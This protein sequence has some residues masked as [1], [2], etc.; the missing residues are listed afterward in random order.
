M[1]KVILLDIRSGKIASL[2]VVIANLAIHV[3][4][5]HPEIKTAGSDQDA[6][7]TMLAK[8]TS[9]SSE[10]TRYSLLSHVI[11]MLLLIAL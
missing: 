3:Q 9:I 6:S 8:A 2:K 4:M 11:Q 10:T 5:P 1:A 7:E